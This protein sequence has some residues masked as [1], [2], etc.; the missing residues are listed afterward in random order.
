M[1]CSK[2]KLIPHNIITGF[3]YKLLK[4]AKNELDYNTLLS[5]L[6]SHCEVWLTYEKP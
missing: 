6:S 1:L 5:F 3:L 4:L 2:L